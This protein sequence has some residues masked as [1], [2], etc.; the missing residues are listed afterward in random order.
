MQHGKMC[1]QIEHAS[2]LLGMKWV[3]MI[4]YYLLNGPMR[5]ATIEQACQISGRLLSERLKMLE[6]EG[7][8]KRAI[9]A[10]VPVRV[11]Y[12]L[13]EKGYALGPVLKE[14]ANWS[15]QWVELTEATEHGDM[16]FQKD[17]IR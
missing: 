7:I 5:F 2:E 3:L 16:T 13:T 1:D 12:E 14:M 17:E 11:E 15:Y 9:Y 6:R 8:V 4:V 10:E